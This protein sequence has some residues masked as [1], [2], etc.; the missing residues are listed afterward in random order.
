[1]REAVITDVA[2]PT[3][4]VRARP[5]RLWPWLAL[6]GVLLLFTLPAAAQAQVN[7]VVL[8]KVD[9]LPNDLVDEFARERNPQTGKSML[10]WIDHLFYQRGTRVTNFYVRGMSLSAPSWSL[11]DTG[12]HLQIKGNVEFDRFIL[13]AYD[14]LNF[15]PFY[16]KNAG[17]GNIDMPGVE[18]LDTLGVPLLMDA[19]PRA[20]RFPSFQLY[21]RGMRFSTLGRS[22]EAKFLRNPIE[23]LEQWT[24]G[25]ELRNTI[26]DQLERE[27]IQKLASPNIRY[28]DLYLTTFD[29][30]AHHNRDRESHLHAIQELDA[31]IGRIW[32]A[33]QAT[34]QAA[35]T[36]L[37]LVSDHGF[38]TDEHVYSQGY[39][40]VKLLGRP[41]GGGHHVIT[42]RRLM[43][44]Y[45]IKGMNPLVGLITTTTSQSYYLKGQSTTY[46]TALL[47]FDGNERAAIHLRDSDLNQLHILLQQLQQERLSAPAQRAVTD[48]FFATIDRRRAEWQADVD[49]LAEELPAL[50]KHID[51]LQAVWAARP[52]K[53]SKEDMEERRDEAARRVFTQMSQEIAQKKGYLEYVARQQRLLG[54]KRENFDPKS[55]KVED[56]IFPGAMG[57]ENTVYELQNYVV[58]IAPGGLTLHPDGSLDLERSLIH[59]D[60]FALLHGLS[61]RNNQ[62][63][64]VSSHPVDFVAT[65][66]PAE[67]MSTVPSDDRGPSGDAVWLYGGPDKQALILSHRDEAGQLS[68]RYLPVAGLRQEQ[69]GQIK[70]ERIDW[71]AGLPLH[72]FEDPDLLAPTNS[73][74]EWLSAWHTDLEWLR[75]LHKTE[76][77]NGLVGLNEQFTLFPTRE[78]DAAAPGLSDDERLVR[79]FRRQQ[80]R[81][82]ETDLLIMANNHW[83]F[84]VRGFNPG[85]NHGS[86]FRISTHSTLMFAGG[87]LT[88]IPR[89]AVVDEPYDSLS[90]V[91]T[92]LNL[93]GNLLENNVP[94]EALRSRGFTVFPGRVIPLIRKQPSSLSSAP[95]AK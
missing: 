80:R 31:T 69:D 33:I 9:G 55:V 19:Y 63:A 85:G 29:H 74:S 84:D 45:A 57:H 8:I 12:Q 73:R 38:N 36:A 37:I 43:M 22:A 27:L 95:I 34:P 2:T 32:T 25:P 87:E 39:N 17:G 5:K 59:I 46:P 26:T 70:F 40:L 83:N 58:G 3:T 88:G 56:V 71:S 94:S 11:L 44:D 65:R 7:R 81:L 82:A 60:Y 91:P 75:A 53:W 54:L 47:D 30:V 62:Q 67:T 24:A 20:E 15:L 48:A 4:R 86:L 89:A 42:K 1:M 21:Q 79:R 13:Y 41:E 66:I 14:Y 52:K 61:V 72:I 77:S 90:F 50:Q 49:R 78:T 6:C 93:T 76:Y 35:Q 64:G 23:L 10:P 16:F 51:R 28:L 68:L 18:V 92:V